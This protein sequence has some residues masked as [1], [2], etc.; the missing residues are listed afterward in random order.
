MIGI[1]SWGVLTWMTRRDSSF[2]LP[3]WLPQIPMTMEFS[4]FSHEVM[5]YEVVSKI[6]MAF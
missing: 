4:I 5:L 6:L 3:L 2:A 1:S